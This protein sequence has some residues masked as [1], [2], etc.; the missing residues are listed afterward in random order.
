M[1]SD[2][3]GNPR[4]HA[5]C[6]ARR[7]PSPMMVSTV[8]RSRASGKTLASQTYSPGTSV[9]RLVSSIVTDAH[10]AAGVGAAQRG[11]EHAVLGGAGLDQDSRQMSSAIF[12]RSRSLGVSGLLIWPSGKTPPETSSLSLI[13]TPRMLFQRGQYSG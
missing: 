1:G 7:F 5:R 10:R 8:G 11:H 2:A 4:P 12:S 3:S 9:C 6:F 13:I